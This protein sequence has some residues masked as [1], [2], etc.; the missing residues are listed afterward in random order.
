[1]A[2]V[3]GNLNDFHGLE[4][5]FTEPTRR[6]WLY[7]YTSLPIQHIRRVSSMDKSSVIPCGSISSASTRTTLQLSWKSSSTDYWTAAISTRP[8]YLSLSKLSIMT[9]PIHFAVTRIP[10]QSRKLIKKQRKGACI[11]PCH[12]TLT[13]HYQAPSRVYGECMCQLQRENCHST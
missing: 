13:T 10:W 4:W 9:R 11:Y 1:M 6:S 12:F 5:V 7:I 8:S 3:Q 2:R